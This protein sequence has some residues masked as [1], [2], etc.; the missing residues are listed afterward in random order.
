MSTQTTGPDVRRT[1]RA[2]W[3]AGPWDD[4]PDRVEFKHAGFPCLLKRN[5]CGAWCGYAAVA[6]GHPFHGAH[7]DH[8]PVEVHGG[9]TYSARCLGAI[10]HVPK[11]G[12]ADDVWWFGF[13]CGHLG[14][15]VPGL[16]IDWDATY[17]DVTYARR[18]TERIAEQLA[19]VLAGEGAA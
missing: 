17:R 15:I 6:P 3:P 4:E 12:E 7:Y 13:D 19:R 16:R 5:R 8:V 11:P 9:L 10:C 14:D 1:N 2:G 18:E